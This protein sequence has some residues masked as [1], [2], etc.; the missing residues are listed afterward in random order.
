MAFTVD[1]LKFSQTGGNYPSDEVPIILKK[2]CAVEVL[3]ALVIIANVAPLGKKAG[4]GGG[5][6][7]SPGG[8]PPASGKPGK[9]LG[10]GKPKRRGKPRRPDDQ[11]KK[12]R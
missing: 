12:D 2:Y 6:G 8:K 3:N 1:P 4:K 9:P 11:P 5:A 7:Y 10:G